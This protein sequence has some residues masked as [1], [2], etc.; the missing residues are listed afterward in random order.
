M[1]KLEIERRMKID[2][3]QKEY[4]LIS[5]ALCGIMR[6]DDKKYARELAQSLGQQN[7]IKTC[8]EFKVAKGANAKIQEEEE[9]RNGVR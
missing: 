1:A 9:E 8:T 2:V 3:S 7:E 5:K 4:T 6:E